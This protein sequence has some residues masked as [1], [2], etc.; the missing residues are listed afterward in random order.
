M[1]P[2][3]FKVGDVV[4][5]GDKS[6]YI[7]TGTGVDESVQGDMR[8]YALLATVVETYSAWQ[9]RPNK[10]LPMAY[11]TKITELPNDQV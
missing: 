10:R 4:E 6:I 8:P 1:G 9:G 11:L 3:E 7:V 5:S 2:I